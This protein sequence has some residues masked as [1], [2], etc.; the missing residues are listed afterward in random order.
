MFP[1]MGV[2]MISKSIN[3]ILLIADYPCVT[4]A[5]ILF[6]RSGT[7]R[8]RWFMTPRSPGISLHHASK[9]DQNTRDRTHD[10]AIFVYPI[11]LN[12]YYLIAAN[13]Q[14][15]SNHAVEVTMKLIQTIL[16]IAALTANLVAQAGGAPQAERGG[17]G[18]PVAGM[19]SPEISSDGRITFRLHAPNANEVFLNGNWPSGRGMKMTRD[20]SGIWSVTTEPLKPESWV[21]TFTVDGI[22][23]LDPLNSRVARDITRYQNVLLVPGPESE[24]IK[25]SKVSHGTVADVW[26][27]STGLGTSRRMAV[28]LPPGYETS[29]AKYPVLYLIHGGSSDEDQWWEMGAANV[30]LDNLI[31]HGKA[32]PMILVMPNANWNDIAALDFGGIR[33]STAGPQAGGLPPA[34]GIN[35]DRAEQEIVGD[36]IPFIEKAYR[37]LPGRENR[38]ITG[39]SMGGGIA[40]NVGL[41]RLDIF[42]SVGEFSAGIF[43][44][45]A[46]GS[47]SQFEIEKVSPE[48]LKDPAATNK[49]LKVLYFACGTEDPRMPF[50]QKMAGNLGS[51]GIHLVFKGF[52]GDHE[53]RVWRYSL[54]DMA[55]LLFK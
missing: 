1:A 29:T 10:D 55:T 46:A 51:K 42:A 7:I 49:K 16:W 35:F 5:M 54:A 6:V 34:G 24:F 53:W 19:R 26:Y 47:Y 43:G 36:I 2:P 18:G 20:A 30:I 40:I 13:L 41:K 14:W 45:V 38:A 52:S 32:K 22:T 8:G 31:A 4:S 15:N 50:Q 25:I 23:A 9:A 39:L 48:F 28:Y 3:P 27:P 12:P 37:T 17:R 44:G 11:S 21:Y 33:A